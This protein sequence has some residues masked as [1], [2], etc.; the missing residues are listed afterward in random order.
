MID[1]RVRIPRRRTLALA[2]AFGLVVLGSAAWLPLPAQAPASPAP[3]AAPERAR[4]V[5][6][7]RHAEKD[8]GGD[9]KDPGL[10]EAGARRAAALAELLAHA[11][12]THLFSSEYRRTH[13]TLA[14]LAARL[15]LTVQTVPAAKPEELLR[16]LDQLP[17][18][19]VA[20]VAG[21][22][23]TVPDVVARLGGELG[24]LVKSGTTSLLP[25]EA[26]DRLAVVT[27][28]P[29]AARA[30]AAPSTVELRYGPAR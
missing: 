14:P 28:P 24:G 9:P 27:R 29:E 11:G 5:I 21:H 8:P 17:A 15:G 6:V 2:L 30:L 12:V 3:T 16:A 20:V 19:S 26:Y 22:S 4:T 13:D 10:S 18:G 1:A 23:N 7:L 25:D